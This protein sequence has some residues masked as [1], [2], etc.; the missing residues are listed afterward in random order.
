MI[1]RLLSAAA[2]EPPRPV[3]LVAGDLVLAEAAA[4]R[5]GT[6]L[7]ER[8]GGD[9]TV[10]R[11]P[12]SLGAVLDD[13]R[14][15]SLFA[16]GKV[17]LVVDSAALADRTAAAD[18]LDDAEAALPTSGD[19]LSPAAREGAS[20]LLQALRL[21]DVDPSAADPEQ[22]IGALPAWALQGG[23]RLRRGKPR[24]RSKKAVEALRGDLATL[25]GQALD[26]GLAGFA[27]GDLAQ[28]AD[29]ARRGLPEGHALVLAEGT[30]AADHPVVRLL[31]EQ[32][33][34]ARVATV[35][36]EKKGGWQ[37]LEA[38]AGEL[39][40][41]TGVAIEPG[42]LSELARRTLRQEGR[43]QAKAETTS[44]FAGEY[45]KLANLATGDRITKSLVEETVT[46][47]GDEDV[48]KILDAVGAGR[49]GEAL[50]RLHRLFASADDPF[51]ARL[52]FFGLF[53]QF[54]R[55]L[56]AV[57]GAMA[58]VGVPGGET[59]Y[60]RFKSRHAP[61]LQ[62]ELP[63]VARN[64]L[65]GLHP[66]RLHRAYLA[67]CRLPPERVADL[68]WRLLETELRLKGESGDPEVALDALVSSF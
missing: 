28:L 39:E 19:E 30:A 10:V 48:W 58:A 67:A 56:T 68:P 24:G 21:F 23:R 50:E 34:V 12:T 45:A 26:A 41:Q 47:R 32:G 27:E 59:H 43:G 38:L 6:A 9:L 40:G 29:V 55:Q 5:L 52:Q 11:R 49:R 46:D 44:R 64:P 60:P 65:A 51:G 17:V 14:T 42:A 2:D 20:R 25:L 61:R 54:C 16:S 36:S 63:G 8:A 4:K 7:A 37:G 22:V 1:E 31:E 18:L 3:Y 66:F 35:E 53:A 57:R 33:A 15:F 62:G 13:L